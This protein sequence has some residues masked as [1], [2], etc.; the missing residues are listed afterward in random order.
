MAILQNLILRF[1]KTLN[2]C[3]QRMTINKNLRN[4]K[5]IGIQVQLLW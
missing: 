3:R 5:L 4:V 1:F 2:K